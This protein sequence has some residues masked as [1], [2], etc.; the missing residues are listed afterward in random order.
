M[1]V[2]ILLSLKFTISTIYHLLSSIIFILRG[3]DLP[4]IFIDEAL[5]YIFRCSRLVFLL[6]SINYKER[7]VAGLSALLG[8]RI[9]INNTYRLKLH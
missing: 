6:N 8:H 2:L 4:K 9:Y 5:N 7:F 3:A 1:A